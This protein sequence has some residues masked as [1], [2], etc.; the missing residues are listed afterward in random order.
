MKVEG[1]KI[2]KILVLIF[3]SS[4]FNF[5][6]SSFHTLWAFDFEV[7]QSDGYSLYFNIIDKE[8]KNVE[9]TY[10]V[11]EGNYF[12][13]GY[14][15][16]YGILNLPAQ[17]AYDGETYTVT[18]IGERAFYGCNE[19]TGLNLPPTLTEIGAYA[20]YQCIG[21]R[22]VVTIGEEITS[23]GRSA[24][25]GCSNITEVRFN[26]TSCESMG[27]SRSS[28]A[29]TNCR[30]LRK[31][32]FGQNVRIIPDYA[33]V[34]MDMLQFEW[35]M[36]RDLEYIGEFAFAYCNNIY[37]KLTLPAGVERIGAYAFAQ[38]HKMR[39][40]DL[41][42]RLRRIDSRAF[43]QCI[44]ITEITA[45][46][47][48]PPDLGEGVFDGVS[49]SVPLNVSCISV[50]RYR[51]AKPWNLFTNRRASQPCTLE[52]D[53][54]SSDPNSGIVMGGGTYRVG[55]MATLVAVCRSGFSF[56]CWQD[57]NTDNPRT[58]IV[59]DTTSYV[60]QMVRAETEIQYVHD[61]TYLDGIEVIYETI[62]I[63][64]VAEPISSQDKIVYDPK[65]RRIEIPYAKSDIEMV[66]LYNDAGR[67][68]MTGRPRHG[69]INMRRFKTGYYVVRVTT[70][71][72]DQILRF[73]HKKK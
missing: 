40:L 59:D 52:L 63:N 23:I 56:R 22:G 28:T 47:L 24:F 61:T 62:E 29:F 50:D 25:Y 70:L 7:P 20:F 66:S 68:L 4:V 38:C 42:M 19:I 41:P 15:A 48:N 43:Y 69:N 31:I 8:E 30:S 27:A 6:L 14:K 53:A 44:G 72:Q 67:C 49:Q 35:Q 54:R 45:R 55:A 73:F 58:V 33:F 32:T 3:V 51:Q 16:P 13:Q 34:G 60:A 12:W 1:G 37:G 57:G 39:Q 11:A 65:H 18:A 64:D 9:A 2:M 17:V 36:P 21:I 10:P 5:P 46:P 71:D 26:A